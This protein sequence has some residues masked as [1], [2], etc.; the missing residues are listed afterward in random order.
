[1]AAHLFTFM[2]QRVRGDVQISSET[3]DETVSFQKIPEIH[4]LED[5]EIGALLNE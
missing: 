2:R 4:I 1:M 5:M 3:E